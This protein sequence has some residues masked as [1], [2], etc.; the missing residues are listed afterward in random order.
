MEWN[1]SEKQPSFQ[2]WSWQA[3]LAPRRLIRAQQMSM[4]SVMESD[5]S[6]AS[7]G[8]GD[9][10]DTAGRSSHELL[11]EVLPISFRGVPKAPE[12]VIMHPTCLSSKDGE[13]WGGQDPRQQLCCLVGC[14]GA[15]RSLFPPALWPG[16]ALPIL[17]WC[18]GPRQGRFLKA[19]QP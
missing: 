9:I 14:T 18:R 4:L 12:E 11:G 1:A 5:N 13:V 15:P 19:S 8:Q 7:G 16:S 10:Q 3:S 6:S 17:A 2:N